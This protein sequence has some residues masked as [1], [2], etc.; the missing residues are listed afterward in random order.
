MKCKFCSEELI[1]G[2]LFCSNC[3]KKVSIIEEIECPNCKF[4][5]PVGGKFC[6][7]CGYSFLQSQ[8]NVSN[9][10]KNKDLQVKDEVLIDKSEVPEKVE[11][12]KLNFED[13]EVDAKKQ[14]ESKAQSPVKNILLSL[15][16]IS[17]LIP[18]FNL[19]KVDAEYSE[20]TGFFRY[21]IDITNFDIYNDFKYTDEL[22]EVYHDFFN[23]MRVNDMTLT[24]ATVVGNAQSILELVEDFSLVYIDFVDFCTD[25]CSNAIMSLTDT[26]MPSGYKIKEGSI[27]DLK[28]PDSTII[29]F[30]V[31]NKVLSRI[32]FTFTW[33]LVALAYLL[34]NAV[35]NDE[36][37]KKMRL[38]KILLA[39]FIIRLL[40]V[41]IPVIA[42]FVLSNSISELDI[43]L[44]IGFYLIVIQILIFGKIWMLRGKLK[45]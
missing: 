18:F 19:M 23:T 38:L 6:G 8:E 5:N 20:H 30:I 9:E 26:V 14:K 37:I 17:A 40:L 41:V 33:G 11:S 22:G 29:D 25:D 35:Q 21:S 24:Y 13:D 45:I 44:E 34:F 43:S 31:K 3:G 27:P 42:L 16:I 39:M 7:N 28:L 4:V 1:E 36:K 32:E 12:S 2:A 15:I 10:V